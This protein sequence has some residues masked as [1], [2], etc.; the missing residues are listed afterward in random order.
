MDYY[1]IDPTLLESVIENL[2][3]ESV[4]FKL[5]TLNSFSSSY[6]SYCSNDEISKM[7]NKIKEYLDKIDNGYKIINKWLN[8]YSTDFNNVESSFLYSK[9]RVQDDATYDLLKKAL[10]YD[11][12]DIQI[13]PKLLDIL[14]SKSHIE[15]LPLIIDPNSDNS[16]FYQKLPLIIDPNSSGPNNSTVMYASKKLS[17]G[18]T[19]G[20]RSFGGEHSGDGSRSF[21]GFHTG[22]DESGTRK[23]GE[24]QVA[25]V[26]LTAP[27]LTEFEESTSFVDF[28]KNIKEGPDEDGP[29]SLGGNDPN[30]PRSFGEFETEGGSRSFGGSHA[31]DN[32][33]FGGFQVG[34]GVEYID[35]DDYQSLLYLMN[36]NPL[37]A[38]TILKKFFSDEQLD[39]M[40]QLGITNG[41]I[42]TEYFRLKKRQELLAMGL[43][44]SQASYYLR[45][46][47]PRDNYFLAQAA[48]DNG[49][50]IEENGII[51]VSDTYE[52]ALELQNYYHEFMNYKDN[53]ELMKS[54]SAKSI[55]QGQKVYITDLDYLFPSGGYCSRYYE[56]DG[57]YIGSDIIN[58]SINSKNY[59][60]YDTLTHE[61]GHHLRNAA[62]ARG[63]Y[64]EFVN[65]AANE[66]LYNIANGKFNEINPN[67]EKFKNDF[68]EFRNQFVRNVDSIWGEQIN[69]EVD[70]EIRKKY[71]GVLPSGQ[72]LQYERNAIR[73]KVIAKYY[74]HALTETG[75][76]AISDIYDA[77][78]YSAYEQGMFGHGQKYFNDHPGFRAHELAA[79]LTDLYFNGQWHLVEEN[80]P[81]DVVK[82]WERIIMTYY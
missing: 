18:Q 3:S 74:S 63:D 81:P 41:E 78:G 22:D 57:R 60:N 31:G 1:K 27:Q 28:W 2:N 43:S 19:G 17:G 61:L 48:V 4:L 14:D 76:S 77:L 65:G 44:E 21:G 71:N 80:F 13:S 79:N 47:N 50:K 24:P 54:V 51:F 40:I 72:A 25:N 67:F 36:T 45:F 56:K 38:R 75:Y 35:V 33:S 64:S 46:Y 6:L 59:K 82:E 30:S 9:A 73:Q 37:S 5:K 29:I 12:I 39:T 49:Y 42:A 52:H 68:M 7:N 11:D 53:R 20:S 55:E 69:Q 32:H 23:V 58:I 70:D 16:G 15:K 62:F 66:D 10:G 26:E 8:D 34:T